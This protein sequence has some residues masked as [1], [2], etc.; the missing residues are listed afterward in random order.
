MGKIEKQRKKNIKKAQKIIKQMLGKAP[1]DMMV[2][3]MYPPEVQ[4]IMIGAT[5]MLKRLGGRV[6][7]DHGEWERLRL[8]GAVIG[9]HKHGDRITLEL[10]S[11]NDAGGKIH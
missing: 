9:G 5:V 4:V 11:I 6:E 8:D 2:S 3:D 10:G 7:F 1:R